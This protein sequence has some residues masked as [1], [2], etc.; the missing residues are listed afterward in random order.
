MN[1]RGFDLNLL[2]I[3]DTLVAERNITRAAKAIGMTPSAVSHALQ[4]LRQTFNDPLFER[5]PMG[6]VPTRRAQELTPF[7]RTA[8]HSIRHGIA[9]HRDFDAATSQRTFSIRLSHFM[10]ECLL[11]RLCAR[12]RAEA[13]GVTLVIG[14]L[15]DDDENAYG[16]G[17]LQI[18]VGAR[19]RGPDYKRER[20]WHD[21]FMVAMRRGHPAHGQEFSL[22]S[23]L[24]LTFL[25]IASALIDRRTLD[26][27]LKSRGLAR[28]IAVTI[29]TLAG[30]VSILHHTEL[31]AVLPQRWVTLY[32]APNDL[33]VAPLP[34]GGIEYAVDMV[35]HAR[36]EK[37]AGHRW[38]RRLIA[39]EFDVLYAPPAGRQKRGVYHPPSR[40][41][42]VPPLAAPPSPR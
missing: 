42:V 28:R 5:S 27:V 35:W 7:V 31:C 21:P 1:L 4:R 30:V 23:F 37:D 29:P 22:D 6:M 41:D 25:D 33:T 9:L 24:E 39:Q 40:L 13:P 19:A 2:V 14:Q 34:I 11:P 38:L 15:P 3:F 18:R 10:S 26:E 16:P 17:D 36:E 12:V 8:L 20:I 32:S